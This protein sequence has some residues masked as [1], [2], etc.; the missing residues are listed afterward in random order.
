MNNNELSNMIKSFI[1]KNNLGTDKNDIKNREKVSRLLNNLD[2]NQANT[3]KKLL[4]D[5]EKSK[6]LLDSPA[7][8]AL[9]RKLNK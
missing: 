2:E 9:F 5:P 8:K 7:A 4:N 6:K 3:L 1:N